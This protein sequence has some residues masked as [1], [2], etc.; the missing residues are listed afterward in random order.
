MEMDPM[1]E[2]I[3]HLYI[4]SIVGLLVFGIIL[5]TASKIFTNP[6]SQEAAA[7]SR[8]IPIPTYE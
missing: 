2:K 5:S 8:T 6:A 3:A 7:T 1:E 4:M